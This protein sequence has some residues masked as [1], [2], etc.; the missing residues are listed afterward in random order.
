MHYVDVACGLESSA[1]QRQ[2][3]VSTLSIIFSKILSLVIGKR[4]KIA[5]SIFRSKKICE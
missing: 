2:S 5:M 3:D 4:C 1:M